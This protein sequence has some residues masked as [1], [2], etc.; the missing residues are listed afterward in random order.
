[1][2]ECRCSDRL[3]FQCTGPAGPLAGG[4]VFAGP[5]QCPCHGPGAYGGR[6]PT[7]GGEPAEGTAKHGGDAPPVPA[8]ELAPPPPPNKLAGAWATCVNGEAMFSLAESVGAERRQPALVEC[9]RLLLPAWE[10]DHPGDTRV[11]LL[12]DLL[13]EFNDGTLQARFERDPNMLRVTLARAQMACVKAL[14]ENLRVGLYGAP[15]A[16]IGAF[17]QKPSVV[18][19]E[20]RLHAWEG[21]SGVEAL[22]PEAVRAEGYRRCADIIRKH[23]P[24]SAIEDALCRRLMDGAAGDR[25]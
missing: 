7:I 14:R 21:L 10:K 6:S 18:F 16:A 12:L 19:R 3:Q 24:W 4:A 2:N 22:T 13:R 15:Q 11:T 5:C 17:D 1:M 20:I 23:I 8:H 25:P 9:A